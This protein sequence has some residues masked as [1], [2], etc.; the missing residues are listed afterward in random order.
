[1]KPPLPR[2]LLLVGLLLIMPIVVIVRLA[3]NIRDALRFTWLDLRVEW[4]DFR[5][6]WRRRT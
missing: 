1:M 3:V 6:E 2:P 5:H 4:S